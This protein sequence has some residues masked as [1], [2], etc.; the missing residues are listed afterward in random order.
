MTTWETNAPDFSQVLEAL[1][2]DSRPFPVNYYHQLANLSPENAARLREVWPKVPLQRRRGLLED[3][4]LLTENDLTLSF[5]DVGEIALEDPDP[6]VRFL[7]VRLLWV[8]EDNNLIP[9]FLQ[10]AREDPDI[11]VRAN[12]VGAL[13]SYMYQA[14]LEELPERYTRDIERTLMA[15]LEDPSQPDVVRRQAL[16]V[17]GYSLN[18]NL[19]PW[20]EDAFMHPDEDWRISAL[21]AAGRTAN[22][23]WADDVRDYLHHESPRLRAEAAR[24]AGEMMLKDVTD[25]LLE[26]LEDPSPDVRVNAAWALSEIGGGESIAA[27]L[28]AALERAASEEEAAVLE[29]ALSN[30]E[31]TDGMADLMMMDFTPEDLEDLI[32]EED[33]DD[34]LALFGGDEDD[35]DEI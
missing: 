7:G 14:A 34:L 23:R 19:D 5:R 33:I 10:I 20:L 12:A 13:G 31:F 1:V 24:A 2:D 27:A 4:E 15:F 9:R 29:D 30:L 35:E 18:V 16:E 11:D 25:D 3:L 26:L 28:E 17:L 21:F 6:Q 32:H 22:A 8:E